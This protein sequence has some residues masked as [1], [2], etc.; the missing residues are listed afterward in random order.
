MRPGLSW[1]RCRIGVEGGL[2]RNPLKS[3]LPAGYLLPTGPV[4]VGW[5]GGADSTALLL[6]L[7]AAGAD[8]RAWH[9][10][11]AW[12][13]ES[14]AECG[15]LAEQARVWGIPFHASRLATPAGRNREA[16][17]RQGRYRQFVIWGAEQGVDRLFLGH[18]REDQAETVFLRLLQGSGVTGCRG[19]LPVREMSGLSIE[20]PLLNVCR[21]TI[22]AALRQAGIDW[23]EDASNR[24]L[25]LKR[26][27][28]RRK[29]FPAMRRAGVEPAELFGRW[30]IQ[31][32]RLA[33]ELEAVA[34]STPLEAGEG[35]VRIGWKAWQASSPAV[36]ARLLQLMTSRLFGDGAT[37]GRR[38]ILLAESWTR[39]GGA[40]GLDLSGCRLER[41]GGG[42]HLR[43]ASAMLR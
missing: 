4:A 17:A 1:M 7:Q 5:S 3:L 16:D 31:A 32:G 6:A 34:I 20:R 40:G 42:L 33:G 10:D 24:D 19:M 8:V 43:R 30:A 2:T 25:T 29:V 18:H 21:A 14:A 37:P 36:R 23:L 26:N 11:H 22:I 35:E 12:R 9:V 13:L 41:V 39:A 28:I 27:H 38:H 15:R